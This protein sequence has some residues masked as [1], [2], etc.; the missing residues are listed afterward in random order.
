MRVAVLGAGIGGLSAAHFL[1][2]RCEELRVFEAGDQVGGMARSFDWNGFRCDLAPHRFFTEDE[3]LRDEMLSIVPM[4]MHVRQSQILLRGRW[5]RDPVNA[6]EIMLK[7]LPFESARI[8]WHYLFRS[9]T[10]EDSFEAM[11]LAKFGQGLNELFFKP[12]SEKLFG[13]PADQISPEW[14]RRKIRV[15]G[16]K[17][18]LRR[19]TKLYFKRFHYPRSGGYGAICDTLYSRVRDVVE[20]ETRVLSVRRAPGGSESRS[21]Y[22]VALERGEER[23]EERFDAI[24]CTLPISTIAGFLGERV[25]LSFRPADIHYL[26]VDTPRVSPNHWMYFA[27][28]DFCLNRVSEFANFYHEPRDDGR[29]VLCCE[30]TATERGSTERVIEELASV[31]LLR[32]EQVLD[33]KV[34]R[35]PAAYPIYDLASDVELARAEAFFR[36][37]PEVHLLGRNAQFAHRDVDE[38]Y[39]EA[40]DV[41]E[42]VLAH[43]PEPTPLGESETHAHPVDEVEE[44]GGAP[45]AAGL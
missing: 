20:L 36:T 10:A 21:G 35:M 8:G 18:M 5:I 9:Q 33:T 3:A 15:S 45:Q 22:V 27:D 16:L 24:V 13:I 41:A 31:G 12:Y 43:I 23:R 37:H 44:P 30:V 34:I 14:G 2:G 26:L 1:A 17:D 38:I 39:A 25:N 6:V 4:D 7:F 29:T 19:N 11:V 28:A 42:R 32:R 40:R